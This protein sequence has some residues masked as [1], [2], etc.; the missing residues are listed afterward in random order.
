MRV[1]G[2]PALR[3]GEW[4]A[5]TRLSPASTRTRRRRAEIRWRS[6]A[7]ARIGSHA[8]GIRRTFVPDPSYTPRLPRPRPRLSVLVEDAV[9]LDVDL[10]AREL[11]G[12]AGV[13]ALLADRERQLVVGN[14]RAHGLRLLVEHEARRLVGGAQ[15]VGEEGR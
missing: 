6:P 8:C 10:G 11:R 4:G 13:L 1:A 14:E 2:W 7:E 12:E 5:P 9:R 15:R 3:N